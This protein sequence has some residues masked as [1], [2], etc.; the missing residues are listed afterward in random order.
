[1]ADRKELHESRQKHSVNAFMR[2]VERRDEENPHDKIVTAIHAAAFA[3]DTAA[4]CAVC[5]CA[6]THARTTPAR[7]CTYFS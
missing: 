3:G 7:T 1:M 4:V 6:R 2:E 5:P